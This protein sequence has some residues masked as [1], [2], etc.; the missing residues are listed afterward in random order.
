MAIYTILIRRNPAPGAIPSASQLVPGE[1]AL[2]TGD[3]FLY[4]LDESG[5]LSGTVQPINAGSASFATTAA[6]AMNGGG[7]GGGQQEVSGVIGRFAIFSGS[8]FVTGSARL[9][10]SGT[11]VHASGGFGISGSLFISGTTIQVNG[12]AYNWPATQGPSGTFLSTDGAGNLAWAFA[13]GS[14]GASPTGTFTGSFTGG[15][16]GTASFAQNSATASFVNLARSASW[17]DT[18]GSSGQYVFLSG[19]QLSGSTRLFQSAS[20]LVSIGNDFVVSHSVARFFDVAE[21]A[22]I[23]YSFP[24]GDFQPGKVLTIVSGV[25]IFADRTEWTAGSGT[26]NPSIFSGSTDGD[27]L[28]RW[29]T[30]I[31]QANSHSFHIQFP[32]TQ[33]VAGFAL[34]TQNS[35]NDFP[36][37]YALSSSVDSGST[38]TPRGTFSGSALSVQTFYPFRA[39][40]LLFRVVQPRPGFFWSVHE[41]NVYN[42][43]QAYQL[44]WRDASGG[45]ELRVASQSAAFPVAPSILNFFGNVAVSQSAGTASVFINNSSSW[46]SQSLSSSYAQQALSA[47]WAPGS[48]GGN[49]EIRDEGIVVGGVSVINFTG[50]GVSA[51]LSASIVNVDIGGSSSSGRSIISVQTP[52]IAPNQTIT[53]SLGIGR[54]FLLMSVNVNTDLRVRLYGSQSYLAADLTRPIGTDPTVAEPGIIVDLVLSGSPSLY[55][56]TLS[57][58]VNGVNINPVTSTDIYYAATNLSAASSS[59]S[60]SFNRLVFE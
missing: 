4:F 36:L 1:L 18:S 53:G 60:M 40:N 31:I 16:Q 11:R 39:T 2:N 55:N 3:G 59:A 21:F 46:A 58:T 50:A 37:V 9:F 15:F 10:V 38:W 32:N 29:S 30:N 33:S 17:V 13:S 44:G 34:D 48:S 26:T 51:S 12:I 22:G 24:D 27:L 49:I 5:S 28:T 35:V 25:N 42:A 41:V 6:F 8:Q 43:R 54:S 52:S 45:S 19:R 23:Q 7:G 47:S 14:G 20:G 56:F 57:P